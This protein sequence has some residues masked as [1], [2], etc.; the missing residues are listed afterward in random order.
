MK[1]IDLRI[2]Q[3]TFTEWMRRYQEDPDG[4]M[5]DADT[6]AQD[7][8]DYGAATMPY[9]MEIYG[10]ILLAKYRVKVTP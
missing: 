5:S 6:L 8:E 2:M 4:F 1:N 7:P 9:F 3:A 10:E